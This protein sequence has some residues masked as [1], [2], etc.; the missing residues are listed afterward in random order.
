MAPT[1][2]SVLTLAWVVQ[3]STTC[4]RPHPHTVTLSTQKAL[5]SNLK[6]IPPSLF[7]RSH[8]PTHSRILNSL[9]WLDIPFL[10]EFQSSIP[11]MPH[12]RKLSTCEGDAT[13]ATKLSHLHGVAQPCTWKD[14]LQQVWFVREETSAPPTSAFRRA[15]RW[16]TGRKKGAHSVDPNQGLKKRSKNVAIDDFEMMR[17]LSKGCAGKVLLVRH[18]STSGLF[19]LKVITKRHVS[20][21]QKLQ[22]TL[23]EQAVLKQMAAEWKDPFVVKL[24]WSFHDHEHPF[25]V[26]DFHPGGNLATRLACWGRLGCDRACFYAAKI[27]EGVEGLHKNGV[28][29]Q[30]LK[31]ENVLIGSDGYIILTDF[32]LSEESPRRSNAITTPP[33]PNGTR[34]EFFA[35]GVPQ[36]PSSE[37]DMANGVP[38]AGTETTST[39]CGMAEYLA[40]EVIQGLPYSFKVDWWSFGT[41]LC[42]V[43]RYCTNPPPYVSHPHACSIHIYL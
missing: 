43:D 3:T 21:H 42:D 35:D 16:R 22:H 37:K 34:G 17:V 23:T 7:P 11:T 24:W 41:M 32:S 6:I 13:T 1:F 4:P 40:P 38:S 29:Y 9:S 30:D 19:A 39:F 15:S 33:T 10:T 12:L 36:S 27:I 26:M 2:P 14:R 8:T 31:P 20:A 18:K 28:I 25:L 5:V